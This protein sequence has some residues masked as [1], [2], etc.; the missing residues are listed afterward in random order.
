MNKQTNVIVL[1]AGIVGLSAARRLAELGATVIVLDSSSPGGQGS[2]AAAGVAVPSLR[3]LDDP[4]MLD[5]VT[6]A[7][8]TLA[9]D[10]E[11]LS[12]RNNSL[13]RGEGILRIATDSKIQNSL[14]A[15]A[16]HHPGWLGR[17]ISADQ[18]VELEPALAGTAL[19]GGFLDETARIVDA[20]AYITAL[21]HDA[22]NHGVDLRIGEG[23]IQVCEDKD[24]VRVITYR[25][26]LS[27]DWLLVAA[28]AWSGSIAGLPS[29]PIR[30]LRGQMLTLMHPQVSVSRIVSGAGGYLAPWR[31]GEVVVGATEEEAGFANHTTP[32]GLFYLTSVVAR[33]APALRQARLTQSWAGLRSVSPNGRVALGRYPG[34]NRVL[35]ATGHSGQGILAGALS[36]EIMSELIDQGTSPIAEAF[37]PSTVLGVRLE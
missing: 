17:W 21:L 6:A 26:S 31:C 13:Y 24:K 10:L 14:E 9:A 5:F 36:G 11:T 34:T 23:A 22:H 37:D 4:V 18:I 32:I 30:P 16:V 3:I 27:S 8:T 15:A 7:K 29:L 25:G 35:L 20:D 2:R 28:G 1:G 12:I 19:L 33:L